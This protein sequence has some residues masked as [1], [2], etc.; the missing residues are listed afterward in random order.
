LT[1]DVGCG[2]GR[3]SRD[4]KRLGHTVIGLDASATLIELAREADPGGTYFHARASALPLED[5]SADLVVAFMSLQDVDDLEPSVLEI[6]RVLGGGGRASIAIVHP[7][8]SAGKFTTSEAESEF[9]IKRSYLHEFRYSDWV[10]KHGLEMTFH[11]QHRPLE[12]FSR[13]FERAGMVMEAIREH[14]VPDHV[15]TKPASQRWQRVPLFMD[16]RLL[17]LAR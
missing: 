14:P 15:A 11:S 4:L 13:A 16:M 5:A 7:L 8:N 12:H 1:L 6:A 2:E 17:K 10:E 9:V 3:V